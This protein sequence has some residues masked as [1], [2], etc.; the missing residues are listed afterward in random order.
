[1]KC[2]VTTQCKKKTVGNDRRQT[3]DT[4]IR[5]IHFVIFQIIGNCGV[6]G[7]AGVDSIGTQFGGYFFFKF[8][9]NSTRRQHCTE[10]PLH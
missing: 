5:L 3:F 10:A 1:M 2:K 6:V 4:N 7:G 9:I 8:Q